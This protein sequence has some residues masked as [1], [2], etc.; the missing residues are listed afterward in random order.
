MQ[1]IFV[2]IPILNRF[3]LL[4]RAIAALDYANIELFI[5]NNNTVDSAAQEQFDQLKQKYSFD[6]FSPR[7][8]LGVAASWNRI[9]TTAWSRGYEF[10]YIGSNDTMLGPGALKAM[11]KMEKPPQECLWLLNHFNFW[12]FRLAAVPTVGLVD[13][14]FM[15]A[16]FEDNDFARRIALAG[17]G[18]VHMQAEAFELNGR[19]VPGVTSLHLGS[20]TVASDPEYAVHNS[21]TFNNWNAA[22]YT[23]KWGGGVGGESFVTPYGDASRDI[24]W[25]PDPA[26]TIAIR[27]WDNGKRARLT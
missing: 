21:N 7:F 12:C 8:N 24:R 18:I 2:G 16:Y 6:S 22:H 19:V 17:L 15:P 26:G 20:Q 5:V 27:D 1:K 10:V 23:L 13:E 4:D 9:I 3:D 11:V 25:W 14:N